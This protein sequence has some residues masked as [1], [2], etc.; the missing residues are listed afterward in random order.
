MKW[1]QA[2]QQVLMSMIVTL[3]ILGTQAWAQPDFYDDFSDGDATDGSPVMWYPI[4]VW[5][6]T[7]FTLTPEGLDVAGALLCNPDETIPVYEDVAIT[8]EI[9]R[10]PN[11]SGAEWA[12]GFLFRYN[13]NWTNGYWMEVRGSNRF[14]L[15]YSSGTILAQ[16]TLPFDVDEQ[17]AN[18]IAFAPQQ[19]LQNGTT[20]TVTIDASARDWAGNNLAP[21]TWNF[22]T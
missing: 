9:K 12:S 1:Q 6:G 5:D 10:H 7:G 4:F 3:G 8:T 16:S 20:Y 19:L 14:L 11:N 2:I 21:S 15:G 17:D 22:T 18:A 13:A